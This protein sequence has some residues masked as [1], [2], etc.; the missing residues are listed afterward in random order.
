MTRS[1]EQILT[2]LLV[3]RAQGGSPE[4]FRDLVEP[5]QP[6]L[7][8][9]AMSLLDGQEEALP[10]VAGRAFTW[11]DVHHR[12]PA[13]MVSEELARTY[14]GSP[15][16]AIGKKVS[17]RPDPV[18][19]HEVI[20]VAGDVREDGVDLE[21]V[22][23]VYW[24]QVALAVWQGAPSDELLVWR[25]TGNAVRSARVRTPGFLDDVR[26]AVW[27]VNP[28]LPL[29]A[30]GP[31]SAFMAQSVART[32]FT[33]V[34]LGIAALVALILGLVGIY[35]VIAYGVSRRALELGLRM[36]L[37]A[38]ARRIRGMVLRQGLLLA[39]TGIGIGLVLSLAVTRA[40][41]GLLFGVDSADPVTLAAVAATLVAVAGVAS[42][43][44]AH[45]AARVDPLVVLQTA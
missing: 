29:L 26:R 45:R 41:S 4:A 40:M 32:S 44:P 8:G 27:S 36:A 42:L 35:G 24:P 17:I 16:E 7:V 31:L 21:P 2:E 5:W 10:L 37:G 33:L 39:L 43:V 6:R 12:I 11:T 18:R 1:T 15:E 9:L 14:W 19:W 13:V 38:E 25:S 28:D 3:L 30:A 23:M 34:L 22:P 20:G